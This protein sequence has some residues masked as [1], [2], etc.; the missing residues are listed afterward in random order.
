MTLEDIYKYL[1]SSEL[2]QLQMGQDMDNEAANL[3]YIKLATHVNLGLTALHKRFF[4]REGRITIELNPM[5]TMYMLKGKYAKSNLTSLE[6]IK[7]ID[8]S[9]ETFKDD[10]MK[11]ERII[12]ENGKEFSLND[13]YDPFSIITPSMHSI[14]V[15]AKI[16]DKDDSIPD[17]MK[18]DKLIVVYRAN[19]PLITEDTNAEYPEDEEIDLPFSHLEALLYFVA[20][21]VHNPIGM[22]NEF[23]TGNSYSAKYE[24]ECAR[25]ELANIRRDTTTTE[26]RLRRGGWV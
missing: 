4:L 13:E 25:L 2:S 16:I 17:W 23:H 18:V 6:P 11:V 12:T 20:S 7:Y 1:S 10:V 19:H 21:R 22:I 3:D 15:P 5:L 24:A 26:D 8:D 14:R 9:T